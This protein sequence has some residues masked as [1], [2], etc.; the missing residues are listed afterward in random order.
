MIIDTQQIKAQ[1]NFFRSKVGYVEN[2]PKKHIL[3]KS[4]TL[5]DCKLTMKIKTQS[6]FFSS[7]LSCIGINNTDS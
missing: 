2:M 3:T 4:V 6:N 1:S 7:K 5:H